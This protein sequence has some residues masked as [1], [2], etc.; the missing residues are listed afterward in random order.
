MR[1]MTKIAL[2]SAAVLG[3]AS[4]A[5]AA[6]PVL[7]PCDSV[8]DIQPDAV[9]CQAFSGNLVSGNSLN[10]SAALSYLATIGYT[11]NGAFSE[12]L[13]S[14]SGQSTIDFSDPLVGIHYLAVHYGGA[15]VGAQGT[16]IFEVDGGTAGISSFSFTRGGLSNAGLLA[17]GRGPAVPEP[18]TWA[19]MLMGFG[20]IGAGM[21]RRRPARLLQTA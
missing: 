10:D 11:G 15:G 13:P 12:V 5:L 3:F 19:M 17:G 14:L 8:A 4:P 1:T 6:P 18:A 2:A 16:S 20:A 9:T 21:R 7:A